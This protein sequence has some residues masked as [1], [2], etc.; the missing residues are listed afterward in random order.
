MPYTPQTWTDGV[1]SGSAARFAYIEAGIVAAIPKDLVTTKGDLI[2][3]TA[4]ATPAR[5]G[6]GTNGQVLT[7]D[8]T[9]STGMKWAGA[10][11]AAPATTLP[12]S[13]TDGQQAILTDSTT[14]PTYAWLLQ[15]SSTASKW[16]CLGGSDA[17]SQVLTDESNGGSGFVDLTTVGPSITVPRAGLY[18]ISWSCEG[19]A[20]AAGNGWRAAV[21]LGAA[22]TS[23]N[24]GCGL[25]GTGTATWFAACRTNMQRTLA[26]SDVVK[27]QYDPTGA[28]AHYRS[29]NLA[30]RPVY[31]T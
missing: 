11:A 3:A 6:V 7:A 9:Q 2:A 20:A 10:G 8:S 19:N 26:A 30:I 12:G 17:Y 21:K 18:A 16:Y 13:P 23:L 14:A 25:S 29:R 15:W 4:S 22:A 5:L 27:L 1:S 28:T 31:V 24:E